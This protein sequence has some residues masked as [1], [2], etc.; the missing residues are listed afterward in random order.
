MDNN[1]FGAAM[2]PSGTC[3]HDKARSFAIAFIIDLRV[4]DDLMEGMERQQSPMRHHGKSII[5]KKQTL[6]VT[7]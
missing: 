3:A 2:P 5:Q 1:Y 4:A 6:N 7:H